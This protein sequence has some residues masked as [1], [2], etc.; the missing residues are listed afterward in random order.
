MRA[1]AS[2]FKLVGAVHLILTRDASVLLLR[3]SNTGYEDG[4]YSVPAGHLDG[5]EP[6]SVAMARE[7]LE[8]TGIVVAPQDLHVV[9]VMHRMALDGKQTPGPEDERVDFFLTAS[10][11]EG[12][13]RIAEP[14]KCDELSW[15]PF[16]QLP[17][18]MIPYIEAALVAYCSGQT[19]SEFGWGALP[20]RVWQRVCALREAGVP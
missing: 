4:N 18:N 3:R 15:H 12:E 16:C 13:P 19:F 1:T 14:G 5:K 6:V 2:R 10:T 9:H 17:P 11:W 7:A 20:S 8:E